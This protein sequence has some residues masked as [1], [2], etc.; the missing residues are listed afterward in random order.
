MLLFVL[1]SVVL[2]LEEVVWF[3]PNIV[4]VRANY[5]LVLFSVVY[6]LAA[7]IIDMLF[8]CITV[9]ILVFVIFISLSLP[10]VSLYC[11]KDDISWLMAAI[12]MKI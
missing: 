10:M 5:C 7:Y 9:M 1:I 2:H 8:T 4:C 12:T 3:S 6:C 11:V